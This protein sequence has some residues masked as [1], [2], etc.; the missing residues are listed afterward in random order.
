[1]LDIDCR[2]DSLHVKI[3]YCPAVSYLKKTGRKISKWYKYTTETV[4]EVLA[5]KTGYKF[6]M[7]FYDESTGAAEYLFEL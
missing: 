2:E 1:M 5:A 7:C 6:Q 4:M 3:K